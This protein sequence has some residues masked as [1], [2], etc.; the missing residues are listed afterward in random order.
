M[1]TH[2]NTFLAGIA[3]LALIAG[4]S[5]ASAQEQGKDQNGAP[6]KAP[7]AAT[8]QMNKGP[9]TGKMGQSAQEQ[10][11]SNG[12]MDRSAQEQ[13]RATGKMG[14]TAQEQNRATGKMDKMGKTAQEQNRNAEPNAQKLNRQAEK[15]DHIRTNHVNK[16]AKA[17]FAKSRSARFERHEP[18]RMAR[19]EGNRSRTAQE[20]NRREG[21]QNTAERQRKGFEGLQG[22]ATGMNVQ[23]NEQ[24][25]TQI[26]DTVINAQGAPRVGNVD[27]NVAVGT[28][29]PRGRVHVVPVPETLVRIEPAWRGFLYFV[30]NDDV[31]IV[32]PRTMRIVAVVYA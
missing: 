25:R 3:A 1:R 9:A 4:T 11:R 23:L 6:G 26:R 27:F 29:V 16:S 17:T 21:M 5:F 15:T 18:N 31:V 8:Q 20:Q 24:Q 30:W 14:K 28:V 2:R 22:N 13:N 7:H 19:H 10:T 12:K 32:N